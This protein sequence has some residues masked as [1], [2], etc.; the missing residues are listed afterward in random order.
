MP[1]KIK[2]IILVLFIILTGCNV[3]QDNSATLEGTVRLEGGESESLEGIQVF[4]PGT[5]WNILTDKKGAF[6]LPKIEPG[7][8]ELVVK[9]PGYE[10]Y[11]RDVQ[12]PAKRKIS[13]MPISL[14]ADYSVGRTGYVEGIVRL[15]KASSYDGVL[16]FLQGTDFIHYT[17]E[18]GQFFFEDVLEGEYVLTIQCKGYEDIKNYPVSVTG[19]E[20][21][22]LPPIILEMSE[23][24]AESKSTGQLEGYV[25]LDGTNKHD[26]TLVN[27]K[28]SN[29][30]SMTDTDGFYQFKNI[31][32]GDYLFVATHNGYKTREFGPVEVLS[33]TT[34][35]VEKVTLETDSLIQT[36][37]IIKGRVFYSDRDDHT[38]IIITVRGTSIQTMTMSDGVYQ[39][40]GIPVGS[41]ALYF[42]AQEYSTVDLLGVRVSEGDVTDAPDVVLMKSTNPE[43]IYG[44]IQ[45]TALLKGEEDHS[46]ITIAL[47]GT[48][49]VAITNSKGEYRIIQVEPGEYELTATKSGYEESGM[50]IKLL[51]GGSTS[52]PPIELIPVANPP[53]VV[54]TNPMDGESSVPVKETVD[55]S[56]EFDRFMKGSTIKKGIKIEPPVNMKT[57]FGKDTKESEYNV[58]YIKL[59]RTGNNSVSFETDYTVT[60]PETAA[61]LDGNTMEEPYKFSFTTGGARILRTIPIDG[62]KD[63]VPPVDH[64]PQIIVYFNAHIDMDTFKR[65]LSIR[66]RVD[67]EPIF[68][69]YSSNPLGDEVAIQVGLKDNTKYTFSIDRRLRT[70]DGARFDNTPYSWS[71]GIGSMDD[72]PLVDIG[73]LPDD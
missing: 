15:D 27:L 55:I 46:G 17:D 42:S 20:V 44:E 63:I 34:E 56:V 47:A 35:H 9:H 54:S 11:R 33:G 50:K 19:G 32:L 64:E 71:F 37:G 73:E 5:P 28:N 66:P 29:Y 58:L 7:E 2:F 52:L 65:A 69:R 14:K 10:T 43:V 59:L 60:I 13:L 30:F 70:N 22:H 24:N 48:S 18:T 40:N 1:D 36:T 61:D 68:H 26:G 38:G 62:E 67:W 6:K 49:G 25:Y 57:F 53:Y 51:S 12:I 3:S 45:G 31:S 39:L 72:L 23:D 41:Y 4:F 8:Y 16:I 21:T